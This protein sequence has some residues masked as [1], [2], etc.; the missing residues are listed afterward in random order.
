[1]ACLRRAGLRLGE[2]IGVAGLRLVE[3][4]VRLVESVVRLVESLVGAC[5]RRAG[6]RGW[7]IGSRTSGDYTLTTTT[8]MIEASQGGMAIMRLVAGSQQAWSVEPV[9]TTSP[10]WSRIS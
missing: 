5:V 10:A 2:S 1:M 7:D 6:A 4:I 3:S 9:A 8:G